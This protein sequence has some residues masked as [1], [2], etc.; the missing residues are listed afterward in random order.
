MANAT[1]DLWPNKHLWK[2]DNSGESHGEAKTGVFSS[3]FI[4]QVLGQGLLLLGI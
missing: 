4:I 1:K 2:L 3:I